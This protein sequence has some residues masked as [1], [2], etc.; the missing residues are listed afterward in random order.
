LLFF[1]FLRLFGAGGFEKPGDIDYPYSLLLN[2]RQGVY[3]D[4]DLNGNRLSDLI[5]RTYF[6]LNIL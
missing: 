5:S 3:S 6:F 2:L 4:S 1:K